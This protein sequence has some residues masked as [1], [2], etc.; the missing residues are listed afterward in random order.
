MVLGPITLRTH[1]F[2]TCY[3]R[4]VISH[5]IRSYFPAFFRSCI[6]QALLGLALL[7]PWSASSQSSDS[8]T[9]SA[10]NIKGNRITVQDVIRRELLFREGQR[11]ASKDLKYRLKESH[12]LLQ[13]TTLFL[14][15]SVEVCEVTK[16]SIAICVVVREAWYI[17]PV[18]IFELADRNYN[19]W[20][21][22]HKGSIKRV[23]YGVYLNHFNLTGR[24]D[25]LNLKFQHGYTQKYDL[26]YDQHQLRG[27]PNWGAGFHI[28]YHRNHELQYKTE[29]N[30]Q[31]F[32]KND[33]EWVMRSF[34]L[35]ASASYR[36]GIV[37][38]HLLGISFRSITVDSL[39]YADLNK[40]FF[41]EETSRIRLITLSLKSQ[42]D[43]LVDR[44]YPFN[45]YALQVEFVKEG[46]GLWNNRDRLWASIGGQFYFPTGR[47][48]GFE[49]FSKVR[50][51]IQRRNMG[52]FEYTGLGY[53]GDV[54]RGYEQYTID[55]L[56][57]AFVKLGWRINIVSWE[58]PMPMPNWPILNNVRCMPFQIY[59]SV[60]SDHGIVHDP[61]FNTGNYLS[62]RLL[63]SVGVG[64]DFRF[65][66]DKIL[67]VMWSFNQ[68]GENGLFLQTKIS[69]R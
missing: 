31:L 44:P 48:Q 47:Q 39:V 7:L 45:G 2:S 3:A 54:L 34:N 5:L 58:V 38:R 12:R 32:Y 49:I 67:Y 4:Y 51:H 20:L 41:S 14:N 55:G 11:I 33:N 28:G 29:N 30:K 53:G 27:R 22:E 10:I 1:L 21:K 46:I 8:L 57:Y 13:N 43:R 19:I 63:S 42:M 69:F 61:F 56:D 36:P 35:D 40:N 24:R 26:S 66:F 23:N 64:L 17:F 62:N 15:S 52:F 25:L 50:G 59:G 37:W 60:Y 18:A 9:I 65:Y 16:D 6:T 68:L